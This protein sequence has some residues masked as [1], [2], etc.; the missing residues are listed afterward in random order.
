MSDLV[1]QLKLKII[2]KLIPGLRKEGY[3]EDDGT[4]TAAST[5]SQPR[6]PRWDEPP[7]IL[8]EG[9]PRRP[10]DPSRIRPDNPLEI[11]RRDLDPLPLQIQPNPFRPP[12]LFPG[13]SGDGMFVGPDHPIFGGG[14]GG[15]VRGPSR[16]IG[17]GFPGPWGGD[18]YL[19][20]MGAPPGARFDPVFPGP[21]FPGGL[22]G[23]RGGQPRFRSGDPDNDDFMPPHGSV[24]GFRT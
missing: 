13:T 3:S 22:R 23:G 18:G 8:P 5:S 17:G 24:S 2:S 6:Q 16:G 14:L 15:G 4:A 12:S 19:P 21:Q 11:G 20:P 9:M 10:N 7:P 1:S